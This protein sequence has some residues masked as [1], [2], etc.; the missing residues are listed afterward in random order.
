MVGTEIPLNQGAIKPIKVIVPDGSLLKPSPLVAVC[1]GNVLT[2][3][4][5]VDVIFLA[6]DAMAASQGCKLLH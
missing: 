2:S 3:Q 6:F 4:R 5:I 1:A